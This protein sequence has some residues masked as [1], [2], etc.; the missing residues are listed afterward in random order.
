MLAMRMT[1]EELE[2]LKKVLGTVEEP[3]EVLTKVLEQIDIALYREKFE[4]GN[5]FKKWTARLSGVTRGLTAS[6]STTP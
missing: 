1:I 6:P 5:W 4:A 2:E 3:S